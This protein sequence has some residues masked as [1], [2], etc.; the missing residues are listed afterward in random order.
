M[1]TNSFD[2]REGQNLVRRDGGFYN[3]Q[4][5]AIHRGAREETLT[6]AVLK[7]RLNTIQSSTRWLDTHLLYPNLF[8]K[9]RN[10][11]DLAT[12]SK[13]MTYIKDDT[14]KSSKVAAFTHRT[15]WLSE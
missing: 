11:L 10:I 12:V 1:S 15:R 13:K 4:Y 9:K 8:D 14:S 5:A 6:E 7:A 2:L 3:C